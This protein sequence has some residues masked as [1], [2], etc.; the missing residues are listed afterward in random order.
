MDAAFL[1][2][3][4][5]NLQP[6]VIG[7]FG[8]AERRRN[9]ADLPEVALEGARASRTEAQQ[10]SACAERQGIDA[11]SLQ[12]HRNWISYWSATIARR[13]LDTTRAAAVA[14]SPSRSASSARL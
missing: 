5:G 9:A 1:A 2:Q 6:D 8:V 4:A 10:V 3:A 7:R 14:R 13:A 11:A 12:W